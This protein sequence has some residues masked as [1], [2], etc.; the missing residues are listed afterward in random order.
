M[1][2]ICLCIKPWKT[3]GSGPWYTKISWEKLEKLF[4]KDDDDHKGG[5][6]AQTLL[7]KREKKGKIARELLQQSS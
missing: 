2:M 7:F 4:E 5:H 1:G 6:A 3:E